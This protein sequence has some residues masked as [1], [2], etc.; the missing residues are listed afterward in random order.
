MVHKLRVTLEPVCWVV[1]AY[2]G[3]WV[4][5]QELLFELAEQSNVAELVVDTRCARKRA[6]AILTV[7][8]S[9]LREVASPLIFIPVGE[10]THY[11]Y[12]IFDRLEA[13]SCA[14]EPVARFDVALKSGL[15]HTSVILPESPRFDIKPLTYGSDAP[16]WALFRRI[17]CVV[18]AT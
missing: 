5:N 12:A 9:T 18:L 13:S 3:E 14:L 17:L 4:S 8:Y 2:A 1:R 7:V 15:M 11:T 6:E 10:F 16:I